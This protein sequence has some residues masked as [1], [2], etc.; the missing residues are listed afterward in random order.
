MQ[1]D[2]SLAVQTLQL[3]V[4]GDGVFDYVIKSNQPVPTGSYL[5]VLLSIVG[6]ANLSS[7]LRSDMTSVLRAATASLQRGTT[8]AA[9]NQLRAFDNKVNAQTNKA[10][11]PGEAELWL[12]LSTLA[13][14]SLQN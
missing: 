4:N 8:V 3:D 1:V 5:S 13:Q 9:L 10:L 7:G 6:S 14:G 2:P 11:T 12:E